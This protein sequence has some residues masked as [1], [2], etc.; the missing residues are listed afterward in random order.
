[1]KMSDFMMVVSIFAV[2]FSIGIEVG[3]KSIMHDKKCT[4]LNSN[5]ECIA[6][7]KK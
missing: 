5:G 3:Q 6:W 2:V 7:I 1:M 4:L